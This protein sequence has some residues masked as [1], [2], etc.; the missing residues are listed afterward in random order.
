MTF[1]I[2]NMAKRLQHGKS[3][4]ILKVMG[5]RSRLVSSQKKCHEACKSWCV[6]LAESHSFYGSLWYVYD[7]IWMYKGFRITLIW[8]HW[9][10]PNF[11]SV[12]SS[13]FKDP[14]TLTLASFVSQT[15]YIVFIHISFAIDLRGQ[16]WQM[17]KKTKSWVSE[18][19]CIGGR[20][21]A[22]F[23]FFWDPCNLTK[24]IETHVW[25]TYPDSWHWRYSSNRQNTHAPTSHK[26]KFLH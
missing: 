3:L 14:L 16:M 13:V 4:K 6:G 17:E 9:W 19:L 20:N 18:S 25:A 7:M 12:A 10:L 22:I 2:F 21:K 26:L 11:W 24:L 5:H 1:N 23:C 15:H 8:V